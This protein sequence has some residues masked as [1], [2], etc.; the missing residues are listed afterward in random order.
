M[1][2]PVYFDPARA[3]RI[4]RSASAVFLGTLGGG[5]SFTANL[6]TYLSVVAGGAR[7]LILDPKGERGA[8]PELLPE[9]KDHLNVVTL[10]PK[11]SDAG[12]LDPFVIFRSLGAE[13]RQEA[14]NLSVSLLSFLC[15]ARPGDD[16][17]VAILE[18]LELTKEAENPGLG[19]VIDQLQQRARQGSRHAQ[20]LAPYLRSLRELSYAGLLFGTG[21]EQTV[22]TGYPM[23]ILQLQHLTLPP[24]GRHQD[25]FSLEE[26]LSVALLHAVTAFAGAFTRRDRGIFKTVLLDEAWALMASGQGRSLVTHLL[27]TG[28][29][30]NTAVYLVT[31]STADLLDETIRNHLAVKFIF[32]SDDAGEVARALE[33][34]NLDRS[35]ENM[36]QLRGLG[37]GEALMQDLEGRVG[38]VRID[39]VYAHLVQAF[40]TRPAALS[41][42][43]GG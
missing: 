11:P 31:Q 28:R 39:P 29:A 9:L 34:L 30:M 7:A 43:R 2:H 25:E 26:T 20:A 5:K 42:A 10:G 14:V 1:G 21:E 37:T 4:N 13:G 36:S 3:P 38:L 27:R 18:A 40:D 16:T 24:P 15:R 22:D 35:N 41:N 32:R 23:N 33:L 6:M 12:K 8:W 19:M 17:F